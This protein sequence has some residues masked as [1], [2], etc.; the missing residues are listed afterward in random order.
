MGLSW[1]PALIRSRHAFLSTLCIASTH[2]DAT[3]NRP[4]ESIETIA[5]RQ[6]V[7]HL[8]SRS[9]LNPNPLTRIDDFTIIALVQLICSEIVA[10]NETHLQYH[11][12]GMEKMVKQR[13]GLERLGVGGELASIL[14]SISFQSAIFRET[15]PKP[16]YL[17]YCKPFPH[18]AT[19]YSQPI[20][21]SPLFCPRLDFGTIKNSTRCAKHTLDLLIAVR[22]MTTLFLNNGSTISTT[23]KDQ[24][25]NLLHHIL[26][27]PSSTH[28]S[29]AINP[30]YGDWTYEACR[31]AAV[32]QAIAITKRIPL[33][34]ACVVAAR[35]Q[36][37]PPAS[38]AYS[39][40]AS[41][42][43]SYSASSSSYL[44]P[45]RADS[46]FHTP[47]PPADPPLPSS[48]LHALRAALDRSDLSNCWDD[49]AGVLFWV[50]LV[51]GAAASPGDRLLRK[52][53]VAMSV[54]C[55]IVLA[56][57]HG[58]AVVGALRMLLRVT[59]RIALETGAE[60]KVERKRRIDEGVAGL[61]GAGRM[62][63]G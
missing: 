58:A 59:E 40:S 57:G 34:Q 28:Y 33:S 37:H 52:W 41:S 44:H 1:V 55:S 14:T 47:S 15:Q 38:S 62:G 61:G 18:H 43:Y 23:Q 29:R 48:P 10:G 4:A 7:I 31:I 56:F 22:D 25:L 49:M 42:S 3:N 20:P 51:G 54:R 35:W 19:S 9:L 13:G 50:A 39:Y 16:I 32:I 2:L 5:L 30:V 60:V 26:S 27:L 45:Y 63:M 17:D 53:L 11:E 46:V 21:E 6:E 12:D 8:I 36:A 24:Q